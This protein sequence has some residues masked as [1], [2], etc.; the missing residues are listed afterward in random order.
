MSDFEG[1]RS[2]VVRYLLRDVSD[3]ERDRVGEKSIVDPEY[4]EFVGN[5]ELDLIESY[6]RNRL[7]PR[8]KTLFE[9]NFLVTRERR[10]KVLTTSALLSSGPR[11]LELIKE[12]QAQQ[13]GRDRRAY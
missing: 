6:V 1:E 7:D 9:N 11:C 4:G 13:S 8:Q 2:I 10:E 3:E 12:E 5:V